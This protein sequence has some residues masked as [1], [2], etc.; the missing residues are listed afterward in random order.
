MSAQ[1]C[2]TSNSATVNKKGWTQGAEIPV[3]IDPAIVDPRRQAIID[4]FTNW[5]TANTNPSA[6]GNN[7]KVTF[8]FV[9]TPPPSG[10]G[11]IVH[12]GE[13]QPEPDG[14]IRGETE[15]SYNDDGNTIGA[16]TTIDSRV[17]NYD[18]TLEVMSHEIG[19]PA[20]FG[21]CDG[22]QASDS[23]MSIVAG[24]SDYN[25][26]LGR[27][28]SPT[29][30]DNQALENHDYPCNQPSNCSSWDS[31]SCTCL[32]YDLNEGGEGSGEDC[33]DYYWVQYASFDGYHWFAT[34]YFS[35]AGCFPC[36]K[37]DVW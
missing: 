3:W 30:C 31:N 1:N 35:Y 12:L 4:A 15:M 2:N 13:I 36:Q 23:V 6:T 21:H 5:Q 24:N 29:T 25:Q 14:I 26:V 16:D 10:T 19:H 22:C 20:G 8:S 27:P 28:T 17:T 32:V 11:Y 34:G 7:S 9:T 33:V 18:A 37:C